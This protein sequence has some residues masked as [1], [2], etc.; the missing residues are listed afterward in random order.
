MSIKHL[1]IYM[2]S[3]GKAP[4]IFK[5]SAKTVGQACAAKNI[6]VVYGGMDAG[7]MGIVANSALDK[8][9]EVL[10]II[11]T[12]I[13]DKNFVHQGLLDSDRMIIIDNMWERKK[14]LIDHGDAAIALPGG[15]GTLDEI[16]EFLYWAAKGFHNKA[17]GLLNID[18]YWTPLLDFIQ[19]CCDRGD[20]DRNIYERLFIDTDFDALL[21]QLNIYTKANEESIKAAHL[22]EKTTEISRIEND[23][24]HPS[25][26][27]V[28][29]TKT[30]IESLYRLANVIVLKQLG[31][32][33][34]SVGIL[35]KD[36]I[37][38][39]LKLWIYTAASNRFITPYCP[40]MPRFADN[41]DLLKA[42]LQNHI[43]IS[44]DLHEKW[45]GIDENL[46]ISEKS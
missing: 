39:K 29:I 19:E 35:D 16:F 26:E 36:R 5:T 40:D 9:G 31:K 44:V 23:N 14:L 27:P 42:M 45:E 46:R 3:G 38:N 7:L 28:I 18:G 6:R 43:H 17:I 12:N 24:L 2:G 22:S 10:G 41:E 37:F 25:Q 32:V 1:T 13:R 15:Y 8:G 34:R 30:D 4:E 21:A 33:T 11:P 20:L